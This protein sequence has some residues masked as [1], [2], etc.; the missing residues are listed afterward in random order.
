VLVVVA[1]IIFFSAGGA[2]KPG[3]TKNTA[4]SNVNASIQLMRFI[5]ILL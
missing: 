2:E 5:M 1:R 3:V 4:K